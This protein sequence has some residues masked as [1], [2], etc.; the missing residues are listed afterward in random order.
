MAVKRCIYIFAELQSWPRCLDLVS[1]LPSSANSPTLSHPIFNSLQAPR[2]LL[3]PP[4]PGERPPLYLP[5]ILM[6][7]ETT[8]ASWQLKSIPGTPAVTEACG[9]STPVSPDHTGAL[10][11]GSQKHLPQVLLHSRRQSSTQVTWSF[12][13]VLREHEQAGLS[14]LHMREG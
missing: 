8:K 14:P 5:P 3:P 11:L 13:T 4:G 6:P 7:S 2:S 9:M 10:P 1:T 12:P